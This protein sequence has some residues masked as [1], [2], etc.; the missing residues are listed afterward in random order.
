MAKSQQ[1][2]ENDII[3][4]VVRR[5]AITDL[6]KELNFSI[7]GSSEGDENLQREQLRLV[8]K[9]WTALNKLIRSQCNKDRIIDSLYFGSFGK[10]SVFTE[11][12][13]AAKTY[14]YCP[15]P[16]SVFKLLENGENIAQVPQAVSWSVPA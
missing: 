9:I 7:N 6:C 2:T 4:A 1:L 5:G 3:K 15:G 13:K 8:G 10:T 14:S 11:D 12:N 16:K